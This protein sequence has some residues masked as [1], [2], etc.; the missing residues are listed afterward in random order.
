M[1]QGVLGYV[2]TLWHDP[3]SDG[4]RAPACGTSDVWDPRRL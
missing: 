3:R 1:R 2:K 4:S